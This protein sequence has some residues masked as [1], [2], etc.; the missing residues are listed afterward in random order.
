MV[1]LTAGI[2]DKQLRM[3]YHSVGSGCRNWQQLSK[4]VF[5]RALGMMAELHQSIHVR[6]QLLTK[7][8]RRSR[9]STALGSLTTSAKPPINA[10]L[11]CVLLW[12]GGSCLGR[13]DGQDF[14]TRLTAVDELLEAG[15]KAG[16]EKLLA[17]AL[18]EVE[19][20]EPDDPRLAVALSKLSFAY[21]SLGRYVAAEGSYR[22][23]VE[24]WK[25]RGVLNGDLIR[26]VGNLAV[27]Y[28]QTA[29]Y[30]KADRLELG[31]LASR[32]SASGMDDADVAWLHATVGVLDFRRARYTEAERHQ[33]AALAVWERL[34]P[35]GF[36][37]LQ[38]LN[39]LGL[40]QAKTR[41]YAEALS[42]YDRALRIAD[43]A[44]TPTHSMQILLLANFGTI[45][46]IMSGPLAAE[47]FYTRALTLA[48]N[49]LGANHP[50]VGRI[51]SCYAVVLKRSKRKAQAAVME[52]RARAILQARPQ[53]DF[54]HLL[55]DAGEILKRQ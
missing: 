3:V 32:A 46:L 43:A 1:G 15:D 49:R 27:L 25:R 8:G 50:L 24:L 4:G 42:S 47:T 36:E 17:A 45:H 26:C 13:S 54:S 14:A 40:V 33:N 11:L 39:N 31:S 29:Q 48:E 5:E 20:L 28:T 7:K 16:A 23:A 35:Q 12:F 21:H 38:I 53:N 51:L 44:V 22:R 6:M 19:Q 37:T 18:N 9:R 30:G 55:V 10:L 52:R 2:P 41:R 34:A